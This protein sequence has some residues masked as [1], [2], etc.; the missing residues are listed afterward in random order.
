MKTTIGAFALVIALLLMP[1]IDTA[2]AQSARDLNTRGYR[3]YLKGEFPGALDYF[4]RAAAADPDYSLGRYNLACTLGV[5]RKQGP[6]AV[7]RYDAYKSEILDHLDAAL[8][9]DPGTRE[10]MQLDPDLD[11]IRDTVRYLRL[12]GYSPA[13]RQD[14]TAILIAVSWFGPASGAFGPAATVDFR[15]D[16]TLMLTLLDATGDE[17]K[18][19]GFEGTYTVSSN[20]ITIILGRPIDGVNRFEGAMLPGG[21]VDVPGLPGPFNDDPH[22]CEA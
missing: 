2:F 5:L 13:D 22:E 4:R 7:C 1:G 17:V 3:L 11:S 14:V 19:T 21:S 12:L 8:R 18:H 9:L 16:G 20:R 15:E 6:E 10:K